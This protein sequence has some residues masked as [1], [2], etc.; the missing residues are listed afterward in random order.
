MTAKGVIPV[1]SY[2][3]LSLTQH[4][5]QLSIAFRKAQPK[6]S[7][8][9]SLSKEQFTVHHT[10]PAELVATKVRRLTGNWEVF[11]SDTDRIR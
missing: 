1:F 6:T 3:P 8:L 10:T 11:G 2:V 4:K 9:F 7:Y 5:H